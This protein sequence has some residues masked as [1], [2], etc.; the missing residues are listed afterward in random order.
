MKVIEE[1]WRTYDGPINRKGLPKRAPFNRYIGGFDVT[2]EER[3]ALTPR[4]P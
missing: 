3:Q 4:K 2:R 1:A